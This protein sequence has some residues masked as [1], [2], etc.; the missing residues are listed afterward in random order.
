MIIRLLLASV[1]IGLMSLGQAQAA[2]L[3]PTPDATP[4]PSPDITINADAG[5]SRDALVANE[6]P[7]EVAA[8]SVPSEVQ[9]REILWDFGDGIKTT[10]QKVSHSYTKPGTYLV[11]LRITTDQGVV[12]EDTA[13][14]RVF[15]RLVILITDHVAEEQQL[16]LR[17]D[18][19][20][21]AGVLLQIVRSTSTGPEVLVEEELTQQLLKMTHDI[22]R[23]TLLVSWTA[24]SVGANS[25]SKFAQQTQTTTTVPLDLNMDEKGIIILSDTSFGLITTTA[26]SVF[27][28]LK[29]QY[30]LL[31]RP[32]ALE[33]ILP[34]DDAEVAKSTVLNSSIDSK[35]LGTFSTRT[36]QNIGITNFMS[37]GLSFL[38]NRGVPINNIILILML[39]IIATILAFARQVVGIKAFG[40][41]TPT[42]TTLTFLVMGLSSGVVV[43]VAVLLSGTL[44]RLALRRYHLMYLPRMALVLTTISLT[45]LLLLGIGLASTSIRPISF[46]IF[47]SLILIILAEEFIALQFKSG[48]RTAFITTFL[49]MLLSILGYYIVSWEVLRTLLLSYPEL[50]LLLIPTNIILGRW[51]GLRLTEYFRFR[52]LLRYPHAS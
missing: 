48:A 40:I 37:F 50:I 24:G 45:M 11:R 32:Q 43:F 29:P 19:A 5:P 16:D 33:L 12:G 35:L 1:S 10:G 14:I 3:S 23:A 28:Q 46:S 6:I 26:Q 4:L 52:H 25:L 44:T 17:R 42:M 22:Q 20:A 38:I 2:R 36:V 9:V 13:E 49:T 15:D 51:T 39:P 41:I 7:F 34:A 47:P 27:D 18:Q 8:D 21:R 31:T 30:V